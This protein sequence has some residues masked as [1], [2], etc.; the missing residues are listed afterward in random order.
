MRAQSIDSAVTPLTTT[1]VF[2]C[3]GP[4]LAVTVAV[5]FDAA[6]FFSFGS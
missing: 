2:C 1:A 3:A 6:I 5:A 4:V